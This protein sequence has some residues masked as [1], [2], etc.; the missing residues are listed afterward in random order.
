MVA[1][2]EPSSNNLYVN[3]IQ[4]L[5]CVWRKM[6]IKNVPK[7]SDPVCSFENEWIHDAFRCG[8]WSKLLVSHSIYLS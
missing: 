1:E 8:G 4:C 6:P 7:N 3:I 2:M 5:V